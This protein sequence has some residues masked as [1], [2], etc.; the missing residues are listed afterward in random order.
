[1]AA[2][3]GWPASRARLPTPS[4]EKATTQAG[5]A[6]ASRAPQSKMVRFTDN[7]TFPVQV[8]TALSYHRHPRAIQRQLVRRNRSGGLDHMRRG[9][10]F[11]PS[12]RIVRPVSRGADL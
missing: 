9:K 5:N 8:P 4:I 3:A 7:M 12:P 1:M 11:I 6:K 2:P 10:V